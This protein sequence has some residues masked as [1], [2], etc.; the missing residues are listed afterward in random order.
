MLQCK[1]WITW[2]GWQELWQ[3]DLKGQTLR[4]AKWYEGNQIESKFPHIFSRDFGDQNPPKG[5]VWY[6]TGS[7]NTTN[8]SADVINI[9]ATKFLSYWRGGKHS[10]WHEEPHSITI[11]FPCIKI[12]LQCEMGNVK[13]EI[14]YCK[15]WDNM[16]KILGSPIPT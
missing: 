10:W 4:K 7:K 12:I 9:N 16:M 3:I 13:V 15:S 1:E 11:E 2:W 5:E 6:E 8:S 14:K